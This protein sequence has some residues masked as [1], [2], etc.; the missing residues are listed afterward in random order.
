MT[1]EGLDGPF[2]EAAAQ[3]RLVAQT[4]QRC[5][6]AWWPAVERC[7]DCD[8]GPLT[9]TE[10]APRG[11]VWSYA[12]YHRVF[13]PRLKVSAPYAIAAVELDVGVC[14]PGRMVGSLDGLAV[15][16]T[17]QASFTQLDGEVMGP[18]WS[19]TGDEGGGSSGSN[20]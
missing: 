18:M 9:W 13:D 20:G 5:G 8:G 11:H 2:W 4:C 14:L 6:A 3:G 7:G 16:A 12:I 10:V 15:G 17:V 19:V 1:F